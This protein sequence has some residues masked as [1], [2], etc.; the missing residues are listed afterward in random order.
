MVAEMKS[1]LNG[2][3]VPKLDSNNKIVFKKD[4]NGEN[5]LPP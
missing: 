2:K 1:D 4:N 5:R 3:N